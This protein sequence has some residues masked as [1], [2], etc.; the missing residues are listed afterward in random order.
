MAVGQVISQ[1]LVTNEEELGEVMYLWAVD[2]F[3][4]CR[5]L[6]GEGNRKTLAYLKR[7]LPDLTVHEVPSGTQA[8][9]WVVPDEWNIRD[10]FVADD[11]GTRVIDFGKSNLHVVGYSI[12]IDA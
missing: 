10:A 11:T 6:T 12:P 4:I 8:F 9:D 7:L 1:Q 3:P 2:L 5:S